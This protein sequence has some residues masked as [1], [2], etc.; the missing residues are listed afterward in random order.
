MLTEVRPVSTSRF[1]QKAQDRLTDRR[2]AVKELGNVT[3][4]PMDLFSTDEEIVDAADSFIAS[5]TPHVVLDIS[6]LPKRFF[7]PFL[8]RLLRAPSVQTIVATY[9]IPERYG[10]G[11]LAE[12][13]QPFTHLPLFGPSGFPL[14]KPQTV[15]VSAGFMKLGLAE[16]LDPYKDVSIRT[17]LPFP[18]GPPAYYRNWDF[19]RDIEKTLPEGLPSPI[20]VEAYDC[21]D[22]F[23]H[24]S[25]LCGAGQRPSVLAPFGPKPISLA[26]ALYATLTNDVVRYTQ[27]TVYNPDYSLGIARL[28]G[29]INALAY[30]I[31]VNGQDKYVLS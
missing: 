7:F 15:I 22:A 16:L 2:E 4:P 18:P 3:A 20:R 14:R 25:Q 12:D 5:A 8:K 17:I 10:D 23:D 11:D 21:C 29:Q 31:R 30:A 13:H 26:I 6:A 28:D 9:T 19:I 1:F 24:I 27:P